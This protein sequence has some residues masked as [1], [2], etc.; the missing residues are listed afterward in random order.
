VELLKI[1]RLKKT[2]KKS[3]DQIKK[4]IKLLM[5]FYGKHSKKEKKRKGLVK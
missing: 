3:N 5:F 2:S 4:E 1:Y